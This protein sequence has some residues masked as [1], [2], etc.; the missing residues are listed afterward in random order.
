ML[1]SLNLVFLML[2]FTVLGAVLTI[3]GGA[4]YSFQKLDKSAEQTFKVKDV[5]ADILP[6]PMYLIELRLVVSR[7]LEGSLEPQEAI[8]EHARLKQEYQIRADYWQT[9]PIG[10]LNENLLGTQHRSAMMFLNQVEAQI[11]KPLANGDLAL[12]QKNRPAVDLLYLDHRKYVDQ[13]V[14]K[15]N[16]YAT[17]TISA[18]DAIRQNAIASLA[19]GAAMTALVVLGLIAAALFSIRSAVAQCSHAA[20]QIAGGNLKMQIEHKRKDLL[21][22]LM[23]SLNA[24]TLSLRKMSEQTAVAA[25]LLGEN[26]SQL[27]A[28]NHNLCERSNEQSSTMLQTTT[29]ISSI[30]AQI[31]GQN[32]NLGKAMEHAGSTSQRV[33]IAAQGVTTLNQLM[34]Q[35]QADSK[36]IRSIT[37]MINTIAFQTNILA[38]NAAVESARAGEHGRG[39]AVVANEVRQLAQ[40]SS[41][42]SK[43]I[44]ELVNSTE[45]RVQT[46]HRQTGELAIQIANIDQAAKEV[47]ELMAHIS[48]ASDEQRVAISQ[49][50]VA[51]LELGHITAANLNAVEVNTSISEAL[52]QQAGSMQ[53]SIRKFQV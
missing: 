13:T 46:G 43:E 7:A 19:S 16:T 5:V 29:S 20:E 31:T 4:V 44:N 22:K 37:S 47:V 18:F 45:G 11:L 49:I 48:S 28:A 32:E 34:Q 42:A 41:A 35:I 52:T 33:A 51:M 26:S 17:Q 50:E 21:G 25:N 10:T 30:A 12:A 38:L 6:P 23:D 53:S 40:R 8:K 3:T 14:E 24:M 9:N 1:R 39:F 36:R 15:A 27:T 2:L